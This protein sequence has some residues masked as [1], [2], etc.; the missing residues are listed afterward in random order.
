MCGTF[1]DDWTLFFDARVH[2]HAN[3][4]RAAKK[5]SVI[6]TWSNKNTGVAKRPTEEKSFP[7]AEIDGAPLCIS[8]NANVVA[9]FSFLE[10]TTNRFF[11]KSNLMQINVSFNFN[12]FVPSKVS[13]SADDRR[14]DAGN[15]RHLLAN[16]SGG[17]IVGPRCS[18]VTFHGTTQQLSSGACDN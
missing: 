9:S 5:K 17:R 8:F 13:E 15:S 12:H 11:F 18:Q 1:I 16:F 3:W 7:G 14:V 2:R 4:G 6:F 10:A